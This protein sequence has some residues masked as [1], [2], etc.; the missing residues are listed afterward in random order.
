M[1]VAKNKRPVPGVLFRGC[2]LAAFSCASAAAQPSVGPEGLRASIRFSATHV[3]LGQPVWATFSL[4]NHTAQAVTLIVPGTE[5]DM[6]APEMGLPL[7]HLFGASLSNVYVTTETGRHWEKPVGFRSGSTA[8]IL[9]LA[10]HGSV[11]VSIDLR[12]YYPALRSAGTFRIGWRPYGGKVVADATA[13]LTIGARKMI[14]FITDDGPLSIQLFYDDAPQTVASMIDLVKS[15]FYNRLT[16]HRMA[17]GYMILGG[18]PR[19]DGTGVRTD[20]KRIPPEFNSR[21]HQRGSVSMALRDGDPESASCQFFISQ[22]RMPDWDG[23]YTVFGQLVG[24]ESFATLDKLMGTPVDE[25]GRPQ[26]TL[27]I[28]TSRLVDAPMDAPSTEPDTGSE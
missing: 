27:Y 25:Q 10:P 17:P 12:E 15:G 20:G 14:E 8:P 13:Q 3:P 26:R 2:L 9:L 16:F 6:P 1:I 22:T 7:T 4:E 28:R 23:Q 21:P 19:G 11:G 5:P 18:D 24:D